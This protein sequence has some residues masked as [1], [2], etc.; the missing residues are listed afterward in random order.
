MMRVCHKRIGLS[1]YKI[2]RQFRKKKKVILVL[3]KNGLCDELK[4]IEI[5]WPMG[6][7]GVV[8]I[9]IDKYHEGYGLPMS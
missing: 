6:A 9:S 2:L 5:G 3:A 8:Y 7:N 1:T 4:H